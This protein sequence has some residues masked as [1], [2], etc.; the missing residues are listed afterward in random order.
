MQ[1]TLSPGLILGSHRA[2]WPQHADSGWPNMI[3]PK[4]V[5]QSSLLF[6]S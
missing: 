6:F 4:A 1:D 5:I 2:G 3:L